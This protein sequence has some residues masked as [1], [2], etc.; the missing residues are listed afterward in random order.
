MAYPRFPFSVP[1]HL[2]PVSHERGVHAVFMEGYK[3]FEA[4]KDTRTM[5]KES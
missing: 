3:F 5:S 1:E 2:S 4:R